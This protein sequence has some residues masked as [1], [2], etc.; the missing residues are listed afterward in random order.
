MAKRLRSGR[1]SGRKSIVA[2]QGFGAVGQAAEPIQ[3]FAALDLRTAAPSARIASWRHSSRSFQH[4]ECGDQALDPAG[5]RG[6]A[7]SGPEAPCGSS[8]SSGERAPS[9]S[10]FRLAIARR[11]AAIQERPLPARLASSHLGHQPIRPR[12]R[13]AAFVAAPA[14]CAWH[15]RPARPPRVRP[16]Q[17]LVPFAQIAGGILDQGPEP[18]GFL[19]PLLGRQH[20]VSVNPSITAGPRYRLCRLLQEPLLERTRQPSRL[21]LSTVER[22]RGGSGCSVRVSY[23]L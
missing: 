1:N 3:P 2:G 6:E 11:T 16:P 23:Q 12:R 18:Q 13:F 21:P 5:G 15:D 4:G 20:E 7:R 14:S 8:P 17:P 9:S 10:T 22:Y 19:T